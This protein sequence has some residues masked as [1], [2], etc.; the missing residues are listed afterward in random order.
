MANSVIFKSPIEIDI[1]KTDFFDYVLGDIS[2]VEE[3][4]ALTDGLTGRTLTY[5]EIKLKSARLGQSMMERGYRRGDVV[6]IMSPNVIEY[7]LTFFGCAY[8]GITVTLL[9]PLETPT[10]IRSQLF[11][12]NAKALFVFPMFAQNAVQITKNM[13]A[14]R[15]VFLYGMPFVNN[16]LVEIYRRTIIRNVTTSY[17]SVLL[18]TP[19]PGPNTPVSREPFQRPYVDPENDVLML[20]FSS[21]TTGRP[22]GVIHTHS[23]AIA[24]VDVIVQNPPL[25]DMYMEDVAQGLESSNLALLP[26]FHIFGFAMIS[27]CFR[28]RGRNVTNLRYNRKLFLRTIQKY[29]IRGIPVVPPL[30]DFMAQHPLVEKYDLSS[31]RLVFCGAAP[32]SKG[33]ADLVMSK[34]PNIKVEQGYGMTEGLVSGTLDPSCP[35]A[36]AGRLLPNT[37]AK[38]LDI[39]T[40]NELDHNEVGELVIHTP[41]M[42]KG[43]W[44]NP[45]ATEESFI[46]D[47]DGKRWLKTGDIGYFDDTNTIYLVDRIKEMIKFK[48]HQVSPVEVELEIRNIPGVVDAAVVGI[49]EPSAGEVPLA[50][51]VK[52]PN[53]DVTE[54]TV[55]DHIRQRMTTYNELRG[56]VFFIDA[57]PGIPRS[58]AGKIQ[59]KELKAMAQK[60]LQEG[61][62]GGGS[63]TPS[64]GT[65]NDVEE[66]PTIK[67]TSP[68]VEKF[69]ENSLEGA[70]MMVQDAEERSSLRRKSTS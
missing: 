62:G 52:A 24:F 2:G 4:P 5:A 19:T 21:G 65:G 48:G 59:R 63:A 53:Y 69:A 29:K 55:K 35:Y 25:V 49:A 23:T 43:Y 14:I 66:A 33:S 67:A 20:P 9:N 38:I 28:F 16:R 46:F 12:T 50:F 6:A 18:R 39:A 45:I 31:V 70:A 27:M 22:K 51:V 8:V 37:Q 56:G 1:P 3:K 32:L 42:M 17:F 68:A 11:E 64:L 7:V 58:V 15:D 61:G 36:S 40:G 47:S 57:K 26:F 41:S 13:P 10:V 54:K 60:V 44:M 34:F 30:L